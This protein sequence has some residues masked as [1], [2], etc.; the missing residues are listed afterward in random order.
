MNF[1]DFRFA[2]SSFLNGLARIFD[3]GG[4]L[5]ET[6]DMLSGPEADAI[7]LRMDAEAIGQDMRRAITLYEETMRHDKEGQ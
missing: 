4:T 5:I 7:A 1:T 2:R 3:F 6:N